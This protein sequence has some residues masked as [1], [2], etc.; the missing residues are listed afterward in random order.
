MV[1]VSN[2]HLHNRHREA[3]CIKVVIIKFNSRSRDVS[4][5]IDAA[6]KQTSSSFF[7]KKQLA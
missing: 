2:T 5:K 4:H 3:M 7:T 1:E 6:V